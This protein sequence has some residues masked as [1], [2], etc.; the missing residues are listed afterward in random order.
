M[1]HLGTAAAA[2]ARWQ[3]WPHDGDTAHA[4]DRFDERAMG[5]Q[6]GHG[7]GPHPGGVGHGYAGSPR[8]KVATRSGLEHQLARVS[9]L[10]SLKALY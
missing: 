2:A 5:G 1:S 3:G 7:R 6:A 10:C 8:G 9:L 4:H